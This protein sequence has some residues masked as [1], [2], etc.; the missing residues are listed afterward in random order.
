MLNAPLPIAMDPLLVTA[1]VLTAR[2]K[3]RK[4]VNGNV[5]ETALSSTL[6]SERVMPVS[7]QASIHESVGALR[8]YPPE[9]PAPHTP[10]VQV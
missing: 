3:S 7:A 1:I 6:S 4:V 5:A 10:A 2:P 9:G 8:V